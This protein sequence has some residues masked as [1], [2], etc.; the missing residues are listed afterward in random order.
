MLIFGL[1]RGN[2]L[3]KLSVQLLS[4][5]N[6]PNLHDNGTLNITSRQTEKW[7]RYHAVHLSIAR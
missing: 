4:K 5:S 7:K 2:N 6:N 1:P 3:S